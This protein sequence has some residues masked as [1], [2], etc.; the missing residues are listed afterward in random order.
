[1][2]DRLSPD[3]ILAFYDLL[4]FPELN[5]QP[6][7]AQVQPILKPKPKKILPEEFRPKPTLS[8]KLASSGSTIL[9][10]SIDTIYSWPNVKKIGLALLVMSLGAV[11][12]ANSLMFKLEAAY[13]TRTI[14]NS[15]YNVKTVMAKT[16]ERVFSWPIGKVP[17]P[18]P[19]PKFNP[20]IDPQGQPVI[21]VNTDFGLIVPS[22]GINTNVIPGVN[23]ASK[24][25]YFDALKEGVAHASTSFYPNENG[26][27]YLFSHSTNY[28]WFI[29]DLNAVFYYLKNIKEGDY[30]VVMYLGSRYTYQIREKQ[31]VNA[32]EVGFLKPQQGTKT[33]ILQTCWP[34]GTYY[35]RLLIFAD[36]VDVEEHLGFDEVVYLKNE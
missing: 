10:R 7:F 5:V 32:K 2:L 33:L 27:V 34:P 36:L 8:G 22:V 4:Q 12:S 17:E 21:P 14:S 19:S 1:M 11:I 23:P 24:P 15:I 20:L 31:I 28:E 30:V 29:K 35:K 25:E 18:S 16:K 3:E 26:T 13:Y 9:Y 6:A